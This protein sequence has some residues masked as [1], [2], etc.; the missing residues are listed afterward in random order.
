MADVSQICQEYAALKEGRRNWDNEWQEVH[1]LAWPF[2][3]NFTTEQSPGQNATQQI[4][5][6]TNTLA[7]EKF[8]AVVESL[9]TPRHQ[10]FHGLRASNDDLMRVREAS[11]FF[12]ELTSRL[13]KI[14]ARASSG[15]YD[16][17]NESGKALGA[18]GNQCF[19]VVPSKDRRGISYRHVHVGAVWLAVNDRGQVDAIYYS[20]K[21]SAKAAFQKWG[22]YAPRRAHLSIESGKPFEEH[23]YLHVVRPRLKRRLDVLG[24][25]SMAF[26][27]VEIALEDK[28][29][30][31]YV[32]PVTGKT[33]ES[34]GYRTQP[35]IYSRFTTNP[36]E[37]YGRGPAMLV[38]GSNRVLQRMEKTTLLYGEHSVAPPL[39][40]QS[41]DLMSDG[42]SDLDLRSAAVNPGWL[43][44]LGNP[45][46][47][48]LLNAYNVQEGELLKEGK[49]KDIYDSHFITLFQ[50]LVQTPEMTAT[51]ALIRAQEKGQLIAPMVGRQQGEWLGPM[52]EREIGLLAEL[53]LLPP[54]PEVLREA[55]G[56]YEIE[57]SS[58]ATRIQQEERVQA[59][60]TTFVD[61][62]GIATIDPTVKEVLDSEAA[63]RFIAEARGVPQH[64][65][66]SPKEFARIIAAQ[67]E[68]AQR[69]E[70]MAMAPGLAGAAKDLKDAG[71]VGAQ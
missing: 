16:Q 57:Y 39:L 36:S 54:I 17:A 41:L 44:A 8:G 43:D 40:A 66:R 22:K 10:R 64:L 19:H 60:R 65:I 27:S 29:V 2:S 55:A 58:S 61:L 53:D 42:V 18:Y 67:A 56:E 3:A 25:E 63:A 20:Y 47:K 71:F 52:I 59:I 1:D 48:P 13:F 32:H 31:P 21:L 4:Y 9:L 28:E 51:E 38:L 68:M 12:E 30:I 6:S 7:L 45:R 69:Q 33:M 49:R 46:V 23:E 14:R 15:F 50:I 35:Y 37:T 34:G 24:P 62:A 5:D 70:A 26:E 11:I